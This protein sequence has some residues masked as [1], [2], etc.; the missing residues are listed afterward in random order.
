MKLKGHLMKWELRGDSRKSMIAAD[1]NCGKI[2]VFT[3]YILDLVVVDQFVRDRSKSSKES[4]PF[5]EA[6]NDLFSRSKQGKASS[7]AVIDV[8]P[9]LRTSNEYTYH[10]SCFVKF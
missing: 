8:E 4:T 10:N 1:C 5:D 2:F 9:R 3:D 7:R 6:F